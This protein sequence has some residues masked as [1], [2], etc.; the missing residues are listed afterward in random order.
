MAETKARKITKINY[1][2]SFRVGAMAG[3]A[4]AAHA[5]R[6]VMPAIWS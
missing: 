2:E 5:H 1:A 3:L 4:K 6:N